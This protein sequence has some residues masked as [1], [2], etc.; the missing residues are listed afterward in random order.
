MSRCGG[1]LHNLKL[2]TYIPLRYV[3]KCKD[4]LG[5]NTNTRTVLK[6][7][8]ACH[9]QMLRTGPDWADMK[10]VMGRAEDLEKLMSRA[11]PPLK[12]SWGEAGPGR[13]PSDVDSIWAA[14]SCPCGGPRGIYGPSRAAAQ[15]MWCTTAT[16]TTSAHAA[17]QFV[18]LVIMPDHGL[19]VV[20]GV[21]RALLVISAAGVSISRPSPG[22]VRTKPPV[23]TW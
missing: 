21:Q 16:A 19:D 6:V 17:L 3:R 23:K 5:V 9:W 13:G 12:I 11:T 20:A 4:R 8:R 1:F 14:P 15:H 2:C 22:S 10:I 18:A 7:T